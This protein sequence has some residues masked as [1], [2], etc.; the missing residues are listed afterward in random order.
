MEVEEV[1]DL[2]VDMVVEEVTWEAVDMEGEFFHF[3]FKARG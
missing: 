1:V 2:W 3:F